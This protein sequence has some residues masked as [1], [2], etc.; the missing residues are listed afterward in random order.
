MLFRL[1]YFRQGVFKAVAHFESYGQLA[2]YERIRIAMIAVFIE[3]RAV[4]HIRAD[5]FPETFLQR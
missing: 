5:V 4:V 1:L 2:F 3:I